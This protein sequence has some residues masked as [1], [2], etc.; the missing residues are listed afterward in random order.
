VLERKPVWTTSSF[1]LYT[2][3][4]TVLAAAVGALAYLSAEYGDAAY[5]AWALL[6]LAVLFALATALSGRGLWL[7]AGVFAFTSVLAWAAF[8]GALWV[9]FGWLHVGVR[10]SGSPFRGF[11]VA[12]L[13]LELLVLVAARE[14]RRRFDFPFISLVSVIVGW[15]FITD[16][17]SNGGTWTIVVTLLVGLAYLAAGSTSDEPSA[18]WL[19]LA[20]GVLIGA[21]LLH[22]WHGSDWQWALICLAALGYVW[23][24]V[25]TGRSSWAV[26]AAIGLL[27]AAAH[28]AVAWTHGRLPVLG[29]GSGSPLR[30]WVPSVVFAVAGFL[31]AG[32]G[33]ASGRGSRT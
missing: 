4:L 2:G 8:L 29:G 28:F 11:S 17:V 27:A 22:W 13:A 16:L 23:L 1:L 7:A 24:A 19:H 18:F 33:S 14:A 21:S 15:V 9:W 30:L 5:A 12:R 25:R 6:V 3:A 20:A 10:S 26:L 31:L 32:L